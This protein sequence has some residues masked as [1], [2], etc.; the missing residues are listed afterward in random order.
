MKTE[1]VLMSGSVAGAVL[2]YAVE[3][4]VSPRVDSM[5]VNTPIPYGVKWHTVVNGA[6]GL[7]LMALAQRE[8]LSASSRL[9][10]AVA[11]STLI[12]REVASLLNV[13]SYLNPVA[14]ARLSANS[15]QMMSRPMVRAVQPRPVPLN[16][17]VVATVSNGGV[18]RVQDNGTWVS[19]N[20]DIIQVD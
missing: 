13:E 9:A 18:M 4:V 19:G 15:R 5:L 14:S 7:G 6:G 3:K 20:S 1:N 2:S 11:G 12:V 10:L 16:G 17:G 8:R